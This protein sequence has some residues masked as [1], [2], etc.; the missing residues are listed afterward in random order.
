[1]VGDRLRASVLGFVGVAVVLGGLFAL[2]GVDGLLATL[3]TADRRTAAAVVGVTLVWLVCWSL[4]LWRV[5][6]SLGIDAGPVRSFL[7]FAGAT[8]NNNVTPFGQAGG[9]P[10][11]ALLVSRTTDAEYETGLAAI[12]SVDAL[13][14]VPSVSLALV[15]I[16]YFAGQA[17]FDRDLR[18]ATLAVVAIAVGAPT[19]AYLGW[20]RR[21]RLETWLVAR[22]TPTLRWL[23]G[24]LPRV[25]DPGPDAVA[26]RV[27][28]FFRAVERV[29]TDPRQL[30]LALCLSGV[31]WFCQMLALW[32]AFH[33]V[34]VPVGLPVAMFVVPVGAIAGVTPL[35]GGAGGIES[36]LVALLVAAPLP[37][38]SEVVAASAVVIYRGAVFWVP[39]L[40][41]GAVMGS[42]GAGVVGRS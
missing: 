41:G 5:F 23:A 39:T 32:L 16:A 19:A 10:V 3:S 36:V 12:A 35:P 31:G 20:R 15:G 21:D 9:E 37:G 40:L 6:G 4:A 11:T 14:L 24:R 17:T 33:A 42:V 7:V 28:G 13:N 34:G 18:V 8:F 25:A 30:A 29:G 1:M 27:D 26:T 2:V 22:L 38:V